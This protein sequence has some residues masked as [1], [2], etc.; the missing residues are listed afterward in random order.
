MPTPEF[1]AGLQKLKTCRS[2]RFSSDGQFFQ[3]SLREVHRSF[4]GPAR[5]VVT[6]DAIAFLECNETTALEPLVC[7]D[8]RAI[9]TSS[10]SFLCNQ[11]FVRG[12]ALVSSLLATIVPTRGDVIVRAKEL[13]NIIS[14]KS[15]KELPRT[16]TTGSRA[17]SMK[18]RHSKKKMAKN[19]SRLAWL[20][21]S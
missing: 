6:K 13:S 1:I 3:V 17:T 14:Y 8:V 10:S 12:D 20:L 21:S 5:I 19:Q 7:S 15:C 11:C 4:S 18:A 16:S 9:A 2:T